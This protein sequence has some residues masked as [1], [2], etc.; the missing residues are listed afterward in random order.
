MWDLCF[1]FF[2]SYPNPQSYCSTDKKMIESVVCMG[3][4]IGPIDSCSFGPSIQAPY[5]FPISC[6]IS[7]I[8]NFLGLDGPVWWTWMMDQDDEPGSYDQGDWTWRGSP[9]S[10]MIQVNRCYSN[11]NTL[12][13]R[14]MMTAEW[15]CRNIMLLHPSLLRFRR[16][17]IGTNGDPKSTRQQY[18]LMTKNNCVV[19]YLVWGT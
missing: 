14:G 10:K 8:G 17:P 2:T 11:P 12:I 18:K 5:L 19:L 3:C 1:C 13:T 7:C 6:R 4:S 16:R 15:Q 9:K